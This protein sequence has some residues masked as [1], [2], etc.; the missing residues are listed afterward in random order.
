MPD[1]HIG[2]TKIGTFLYIYLWGCIR[3]ITLYTHLVH[4]EDYKS[5]ETSIGTTTR[6]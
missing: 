4:R 3:C 1:V 2:L 5:Y 6:I